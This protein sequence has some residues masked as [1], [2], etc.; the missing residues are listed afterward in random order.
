MPVK[1]TIISILLCASI[2]YA[3]LGDKTVIGPTSNLVPKTTKVAGKALSGDIT[4]TA[5]D[6]GAKSLTAFQSYSTATQGKLDLKLNQAVFNSYTSIDRV[7]TTRTVNGQALS[8]DVTVT[9]ISGN[10]GTATALAANGTNCSAGQA[11][12]GV[13]ASGNSEGCYSVQAPLVAG[14]DYL[15]PTGSAAALTSFPTL[16]QNT[17]GSAAKLTTGRTIAITGPITYTSPSFDGS[18]NVTAASAVAAQTGTGSTFVMSASPTITTNLTLTRSDD[19]PNVIINRTVT[20]ITTGN[21]SGRVIFGAYDGAANQQTA[22]IRTVATAD[23]TTNSCPVRLDFE[24]SATTGAARANRMSIKPT[25][26]VKF[27]GLSADPAGAE[28]GDFY[29]NSTTNK[30]RGYAAGAWVD[31][32]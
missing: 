13:D 3:A 29:Y 19:Q 22:A 2:S 7:P 27:I 24:T 4:L 11:P 5:A 21:S 12:L 23:H 18:G 6:V 8:G 31:L 20:A 9:T 32:H 1:R 10:A 30:F 25:G 14:T 26:Q 17:T 15:A 16:N 28:N